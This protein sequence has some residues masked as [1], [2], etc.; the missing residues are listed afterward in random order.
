MG[1]EDL[2]I[3]C[4]F[5]GLLLLVVLVCRKEGYGQ[6]ASVR[7]SAGSVAGPVGLYG[8]DPVAVF[9]RQIAEMKSKEPFRPSDD[10]CSPVEVAPAH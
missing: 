3:V 4:V 7:W 6:D 8:E 5:L 9:A 10:W 2:L 1:S